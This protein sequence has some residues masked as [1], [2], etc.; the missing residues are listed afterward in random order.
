[1]KA[2]IESII[3]IKILYQAIVIA[4]YR[5]RLERIFGEIQSVLKKCSLDTHHDVQTT[6][7]HLQ[8]SSDLVIKGYLS[9]EMFSLTVY[10]AIPTIV[11]IFKYATTGIVPALPNMLEADFVLFDYTSNFWIWLPV[12][13]FS[14]VI[15]VYNT[16]VAVIQDS[17]FWCLLHHVSGVFKIIRMQIVQL[18]EFQEAEQFQEKLSEIVQ[19]QGV[20]YRS[21][22]ELKTTLSSLLLLL[23]GACMLILCMTMMVLTIASGDTDLLSKMGVIV[24]FIFFQIFSFSML[25]TELMTACS[26]IADAIYDT[27]WYKRSVPEQRNIQFVLMRSQR[28]ATLTAANFFGV[29]RAT[30]AMTIRSAF[31]YFTVLRQFYG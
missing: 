18:D 6:L 16:I 27:N 7:R 28:M 17:F 10:C 15:I 9:L 24:Y 1:M 11:T 2:L 25:G 3:S 5:P 26:A 22:K 12:A 29:N 4:Y 19:M 13:L 23:Y 20:A 14:D 31:S 8:T 30:F 21:A